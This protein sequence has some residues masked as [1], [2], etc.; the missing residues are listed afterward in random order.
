VRRVAAICRRERAVVVLI[1]SSSA[2]H[3]L[4][5]AS[6]SAR[7][8]S[9]R[10]WM[11][12]HAARRVN[13]SPPIYRGLPRLAGHVRQLLPQS[14]SPPPPPT[15]SRRAMAGYGSDEDG[16]TNNGFGRRSLHTSGRADCCT[17]RATWRRRTSARPKDGV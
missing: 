10:R 2:H 15:S 17:R 8:K 14:T 5:R 13:A 11:A 1:V 3:R 6:S 9:C 7:C 12:S 4:P 16:A